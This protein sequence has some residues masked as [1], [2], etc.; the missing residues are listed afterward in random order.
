MGK[1]HTAFVN[2][3]C[4]GL[5][6]RV[7]GCSA[8]MKALIAACWHANPSSRPCLSFSISFS[9]CFSL[10]L[11]CLFFFTFISFFACTHQHLMPLLAHSVLFIDSPCSLCHLSHTLTFP[12]CISQ[13]S[14][15]PSPSVPCLQCATHSVSLKRGV[16]GRSPV[17]A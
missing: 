9:P 14:S 17:V 16:W 2:A 10:F 15:H 11:S 12:F 4:Q 3:V 1:T 8:E 5:R 13:R 6:P 7:S